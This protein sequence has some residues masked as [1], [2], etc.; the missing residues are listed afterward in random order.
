M[1]QTASGIVTGSFSRAYFGPETGS[2]NDDGAVKNKME[3]FPAAIS[4][5]S[6]TVPICSALQTFSLLPSPPSPLLPETF[7]WSV[8]E[9][10]GGGAAHAAAKMRH[11]SHTL[12]HPP[13]FEQRCVCLHVCILSL[14]LSPLLQRPPSLPPSSFLFLWLLHLLR[15]LAVRTLVTSSLMLNG[16]FLAKEEQGTWNERE[17]GRGNKKPSRPAGTLLPPRWVIDVCAACRRPCWLT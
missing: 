4:V 9:E 7:T 17:W 10:S 13:P 15:V 11:T 2:E 3:L 12:P 8:E 5:I 16:P 14:S 6:R 1:W